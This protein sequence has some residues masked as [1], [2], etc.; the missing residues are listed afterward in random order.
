M[1]WFIEVSRV[2]EDSQ[3]EKHCLEAKQWQA[4]LQEARRRRGDSGPLSKFSIELL[5]EGYRAVDPGQSVRYLVK[6]APADAPLINPAAAKGFVA[7]PPPKTEPMAAPAPVSDE[8]DID[9]EVDMAAA[10]D[11]Q[12]APITDPAASKAP[13]TERM[14]RGPASS[15]PAK[16]PEPAKKREPAKK[17]SHPNIVVPEDAVPPPPKRVSSAPA[18]PSSPAPVEPTSPAPAKSSPAAAAVAS[19]ARS[20]VRP[21]A[22]PT[23]RSLEP[24]RAPDF[25]VIRKREEQPSES[26][27]IIYREYAYAVAPGTTEAAAEVLLWLRF[28]ELNSALQNETARKFVQ[29][30]VF[31]HV[32]ERRPQRAPLATL[33]WKDWRGDPV[34]T[35]PH[36]KAGA[37][38]PAPVP[39][40]PSASTPAPAAPAASAP[41]PALSAPAPAPS[42]PAPAPSVPAPAASAPAPAPS[43]PAPAAS[44]PAPAPSPSAPAP[45]APAAPSAPT[46]SGTGP[47]GPFA[48]APSAPDSASAPRSNKGRRRAGEDLIGELFESMHDLHFIPD[49]VGGVEFVLGIVRS[50]LPSEAALV[51]VFDINARNF[52]VVRAEGG[53]VDKV[54]L[55]RTPDTHPLFAV[56]MRRTR[57]TRIDD[58]E[59]DPRFTD[60]RWAALGVKP[61][62][63]LFG[64]VQLGGRYLGAIELANPEGG[65]PYSEHEAHALDYIC[66][67]LA[68]FLV[69]RPI[70]LDP[71][72]VLPKS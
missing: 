24:A 6:K 72:V 53:Q 59:D 54:L 34:L 20:S 11:P 10:T 4:A 30:A 52:I 40:A 32:F 22:H 62:V 12:A 43:V 49:M 15:E 46:I 3:T 50:T 33:A 27:P 37:P 48:P 68:E 28:R 23:Q 26:S 39:P 42:V 29:L 8:L 9:V 58:A 55:H 45:S 63:A 41:A 47:V 19:G 14:S 65:T 2:G 66:E 35:F 36:R 60:G 1:R 71:D 69:N 7:E 56:S 38:T 67:Q 57:A 16:K 13:I 31:D 18:K 51:H 61:K 64:S 44:A 17:A 70:I 5:D 21:S 25:T